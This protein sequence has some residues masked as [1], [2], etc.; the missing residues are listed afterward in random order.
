M[1]LDES[2]RMSTLVG[3]LLDLSRLEAGAEGVHPVTVGQVIFTAFT[4]NAVIPA[5]FSVWQH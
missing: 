2:D 3:H 1:I 4:G 5:S